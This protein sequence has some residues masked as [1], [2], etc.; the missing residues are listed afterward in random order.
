MKT[1]GICVPV[2]ARSATELIEKIEEAARL[3]D[4][5]E[6][7]FDCL[8]KTELFGALDSLPNISKTCILTYRSKQQGGAQELNL[9]ERHNF[10]ERV[11]DEPPV[12]DFLGDI[13]LGA[14]FPVKLRP[15]RMIASVHDFEGGSISD[16]GDSIFETA[17]SVVKI[18]VSVEDA[19]NAL[20]IWNLLEKAKEAGKKVIPIAMGEAGKWT[21]ILGPAHGAFL[22]YASLFPA[23][24]TA[25]GQI[26]AGEMIETFRVREITPETR[27][28]GILAGDTGYSMSP[29]IH[30]AAFR[31]VGVDSVFVP[32]QV[33]DMA[34]F[35]RR[36][37]WAES[38]E[39]ELNFH[40]FSVTNP[41]KQAIL[42]FL[43]ETDDAARVIG[44]VNTVKIENDRLFGYNTDAEGFIGALKKR[45]GDLNG[46]R[47]AVVGGGGAARACIYALKREGAAVS[48]FARK[49]EQSAKLAKDFS[50]ECFGF[51]DG[52]GDLKGFDI[53]V[54]ATPLGTRG[55]HEN[56][57]ISDVLPLD[58]VKLVYDLIY[59][60]AETKLLKAAGAAGADTLGG[61]A[62]LLGQAAEQFRIWTG[63]R[64]PIETMERAALDRLLLYR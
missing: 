29:Y 62:M 28:Y 15:D 57:S 22:T 61:L 1:G 46:A 40:G 45:S 21:R 38:R 19:V 26:T 47:A 5:V 39:V 9:H 12:A 58:G 52:S 32:F 43:D 24:A 3:A 41:H 2:C 54:N 25:A 10:W 64:P 16:L 56:A 4:L 18:A 36:M 48:S 6:V 51:G 35:M 63:R 55:E 13:E 20:P 17:A 44:A 42:E 50:V 33:K 27:V 60:P 31:E 30:N 49:A 34:G 7:R 11:A 14:E 59:N 53:V 8:D 23:D 37:A